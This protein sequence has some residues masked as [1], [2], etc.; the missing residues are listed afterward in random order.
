MELNDQFLE[1]FSERIEFRRDSDFTVDHLTGVYHVQFSVPA[2]GPEGISDPEYL[3]TLDAFA[4]WYRSQ[5]GV[6]HVATFTDTMKRLNMNMHG[7]D[8]D[9]YR[10]PGERPLA[11]QYLLLYEMSLPFGL[12]LNNTVNIDKSALKLTVTLGRMTTNE[13]LEKVRAGERWLA[14]NAPAYMHTQGVGTGVMFAHISSRNIRSMLAGTMLALLLISATLIIAFRS[15]RLGLLSMIPNFI[16]AGIAF[17]I[18]AMTVGTV[19]VAVSIVAGMTLGIIVDDTV[20]FM[21]KYLRAR[22]EKRSDGADAVR[23]AFATVG[24]ALVVTSIMLVAG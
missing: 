20:H 5:P 12:D 22:R 13:L 17:G 23:Y 14:E 2:D 4:N 21:S 24:M 1:Y 11:A 6:V 10:L 18:W 16:P 7:D 15:V 3:E 19:N 9:W 8:R